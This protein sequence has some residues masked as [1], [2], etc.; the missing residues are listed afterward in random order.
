MRILVMLLV[1]S[2]LVLV[3]TGA[4]GDTRTNARRCDGD[5]DEF[6]ARQVLD[7]GIVLERT[8]LDTGV[9]DDGVRS[10]TYR[11]VSVRRTPAKGPARRA[12]ITMTLSGKFFFLEK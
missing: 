11:A 4:Y 6:Q 7:E 3:S 1:A 8:A 12:R 2:A 5:P 9:R 10:S